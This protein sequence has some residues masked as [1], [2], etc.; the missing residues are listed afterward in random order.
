M[1]VCMCKCVR[2]RGGRGGRGGRGLLPLSASWAWSKAAAYSMRAGELPVGGLLRCVVRSNGC[3]N[4]ACTQRGMHYRLAAEGAEAADSLCRHFMAPQRLHQTA[5]RGINGNML[6]T[7]IEAGLPRFGAL[8]C[9]SG[10]AAAA[11]QMAF[12]PSGRQTM[13]SLLNM[14]C[15][16]PQVCACGASLLVG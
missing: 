11:A 5:L 15:A 9:A 3:H 1:G 8:R 7:A 2:A 13:L 14:E 16:E 4:C 6:V 10:I 12:L